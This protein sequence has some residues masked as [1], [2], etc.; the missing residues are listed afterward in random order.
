MHSCN[1]SSTSETHAILR[2]STR[3]ATAPTM[4]M[5]SSRSGTMRPLLF[6]SSRIP[7][8][9]A[10]SMG[11]RSASTWVTTTKALSVT[12]MA[13]RSTT[14]SSSVSHFTGRN[15]YGG[16]HSTTNDNHYSLFSSNGMK[17]VVLSLK[18]DVTP[19]AD[20]LDWADGVVS[21]YPDRWAIVSSHYLID[22]GVQGNFSALG[23]A[24]YDRLKDNP[25]FFLMIC[26]HI[27]GEGRRSD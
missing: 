13:P 20:V 10:A 26:S 16:H 27:A 8:R 7:S 19:N 25:N 6:L 3:P 24:L 5:P 12:R 17:F 9:R 21:A 18:Y 2:G 1:G 15:Y 11:C 14:T 23:Q 22:S 4:A